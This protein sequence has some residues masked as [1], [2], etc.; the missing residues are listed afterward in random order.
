M[1][2][3]EKWPAGPWKSEPDLLYWMTNLG[4]PALIRR[5]RGF[6][7][8]T[9]Y[10]GVPNGHR[11]FKRKY[12]SLSY[13]VHGGLSFADYWPEFPDHWWIG[14]DCNHEGDFAPMR[15]REFNFMDESP[16][17]YRTISYVKQE[18]ESLARQI[19]R[20]KFWVNTYNL[21]CEALIELSFLPND[22]WR[23]ISDQLEDAFGGDPA[24]GRVSNAISSQLTKELV[25]R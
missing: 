8:L 23:I 13:S 1:I 16:D 20:A 2:D 10:V 18:C 19:G 5:N 7:H 22:D 4:L 9:G 6:G 14:F 11:D 24:V 3:K 21:F 17:S 12:D 15:P 25:T